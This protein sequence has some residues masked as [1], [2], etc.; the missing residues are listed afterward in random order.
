MTAWIPTYLKDMAAYLNGDTSGMYGMWDSSTP[1]LTTTGKVQ[2]GEGGVDLTAPTGTPVYALATG[3][4]VGAGYWNNEEHGVVTQEVNVPGVGPQRL[5]YQH[6]YLDPSIQ[7][8]TGSACSQVIQRGQKIGTVGGYGETEMGFNSKWGGIWG[9]NNPGTWVRDPRPWLAALMT[10]TPP[11]ISSSGGST[12]GGG[13]AN[14]Q[15]QFHNEGVKIGLVLIAVIVASF[16]GYIL[17]QKQADALMKKGLH[18]A[19]KTAEV[20]AA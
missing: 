15:T 9:E 16:G 19:E 2:P 13:A 14:W 3:P 6:I 5:Y 12:S 17:F 18:V 7:Q 8:C 1:G 10:G 4:V 11:P 20:A